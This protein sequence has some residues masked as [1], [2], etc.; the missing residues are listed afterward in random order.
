M[1]YI[2]GTLI[3]LMISI[4]A[5]SQPEKISWKNFTQSTSQLPDNYIS[6]I[7]FDQ[8]GVAWIATWGG[9]IVK[10]EGDNW[11]VFNTANSKLPTNTINDL[12][13]D[14]SGNIWAATDG[15]GVVDINNWITYKL[16]GDNYALTL[17]V[18]DQNKLWVGTFDDGLFTMEGKKFEKQWSTG[19]Y[20]EDGVNDI[21][22]DGDKIWIATRLGVLEYNGQDWV[23]YILKGVVYDLER[24]GNGQIWASMAP[25][26]EVAKFDGKNWSYYSKPSSVAGEK[27]S[28]YIQ[29]MYI[30]PSNHIF[31]NDRH[32]NLSKFEDGMWTTVPL[33][34]NRSGAGPGISAIAKDAEGNFWIGTYNSGLFIQSKEEIKPPQEKVDLEKGE[35]LNRKIEYQHNISLKNNKLILEIWDDQKEDGDII[36]LSLNGNWIIE[37][38][39]LKK[40]PHIIELTL[41]QTGQNLLILY[42]INLGKSPPNTAAI[43]VSD[44]ENKKKFVL[45]SDTKTSGTI[46]I[47]YDPE[48]K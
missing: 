47:F 40:Q 13:I 8:K 22:F 38:F 39:E 19:G 27:T 41:D 32:G 2:F 35:F 31:L 23:K 33:E 20:F 43:S 25:G 18:D 26:G 30:D 6:S 34:E 29:A 24:D 17:A 45:K 4:L 7:V 15:K 46:S 14:K 1:K 3:F 16:P 44:G 42:A 21:V 12:A 37:N 28:N 5:F 48:M 10:I 11:T 9:G 36:S